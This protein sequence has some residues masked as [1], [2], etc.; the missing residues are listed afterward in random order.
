MFERG[1]TRARMLW[2]C[3][4]S[5]SKASQTPARPQPTQAESHVARQA[6]PMLKKSV[7]WSRYMS[8]LCVVSL[9]GDSYRGCCLLSGSAKRC[10]LSSVMWLAITLRLYLYS[11][12]QFIKHNM[13]AK[14]YLYFMRVVLRIFPFGLYLFIYISIFVMPFSLFQ[15]ELYI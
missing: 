5:D 9:F 10:R 2:P 1:A 12:S 3:L 8:Y 4:S 13:I 11:I 15:G 7:I 14:S 6:D